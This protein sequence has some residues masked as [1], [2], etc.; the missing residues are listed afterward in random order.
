MN[1]PVRVLIADDD[2]LFVDASGRCRHR[3]G[4]G[5]RRARPRRGG[6]DGLAEELIPD[7]VLMDLSM[8]VVDG[9]EASRRIGAAAWPVSLVVLSGSSDRG[10]VEKPTTRARPAT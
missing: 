8:P 3:N 1:E 5:D 4:H 10:D 6:G 2:P 7:V 9:F